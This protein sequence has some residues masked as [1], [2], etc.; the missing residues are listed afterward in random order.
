MGRAVSALGVDLDWLLRAPPGASRVPPFAAGWLIDERTRRPF[1][2]Y[3][4]ATAEESVHWSEGYEQLH[5][6]SS[7]THFIDLWTRRAMLA[8]LGSLSRGSTAIDIGCAAGYMLEDLR[9]SAPQA[10]LIGVDLLANGLRRAHA[11]TPDALLLQ[12]DVC[13]LPLADESVDAVVSAN[14]LEH[15]LHDERALAEIFRIMKPGARAVIVV[16][17]GPGNYDYLD[18]IGGHVR[19]YARGELARKARGAGLIVLEEVCL[20]ALLYPA[21]WSVKQRNRRFH[22]HLRG[23]ALERRV[24]SD[25]EGTRDSRLGHLACRIEEALLDRGVKLPFGIRSLTVLTRPRGDIRER[26]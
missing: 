4:P 18:R 14:V 26:R 7:R 16:P 17:L 6:E 21:F 24:A 3:V 22:D 10:T 1:L 12:A 13:E 20:G 11:C 5:A 25:A 9:A 8:R 19:R 23:E 2:S 15:V